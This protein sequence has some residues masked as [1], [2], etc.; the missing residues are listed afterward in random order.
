MLWVPDVRSV[1]QTSRINGDSVAHLKPW[2]SAKKTS[3]MGCPR[4]K[5]S[6]VVIDILIM[7]DHLLF[8]LLKKYH[9][10]YFITVES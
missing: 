3:Q 2:Q 6:L 9:I 10:I 8:I 4:R 5:K 1:T 7:F